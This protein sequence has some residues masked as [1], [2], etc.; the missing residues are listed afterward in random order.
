MQW[1]NLETLEQL[2][3]IKD[4]AG[5]QVIFKHSTRCSVSM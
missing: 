3:E 4:A 1:R 2:N 5:Y